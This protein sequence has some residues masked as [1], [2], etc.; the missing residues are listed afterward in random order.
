MR[1]DLG[2]VATFKP[3]RR[4]IDPKLEM[5]VTTLRDT[6]TKEAEHVERRVAMADQLKPVRP[7]QWARMGTPRRLSCHRES[8]HAWLGLDQRWTKP[9]EG[10]RIRA[11][12]IDS[13]IRQGY[14]DA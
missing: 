1:A 9:A 4:Q 7:R 12:A 8:P 6:C 14:R 5:Y 11:A 10:S 2:H 13:E 3:Q